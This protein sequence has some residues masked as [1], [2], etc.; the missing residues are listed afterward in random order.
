MRVKRPP[1]CLALLV[2]PVVAMGLLYLRPASEAAP[3]TVIA[4]KVLTVTMY[5]T[6]D[7]LAGGTGEATAWV[8]NDTLDRLIDIPGAYSPLYCNASYDHCLTITGEGAVNAAASLMA[9]A[10]SDRLDLSRTYLMLAG[11][12]GTPP[13]AGTLGAAAWGDWVVAAD[14]INEIDARELPLDVP[15]PKFRWGCAVPWCDTS[16]RVGVEVFR[17]N[18][19][20]T[21]WA[22][23]LS[24]DVP[25]ADNDTARAYRS[26]FP[27]GLPARQAPF[28]TTCG[29][30]SDSTFWAGTLLSNWATWWMQQWTDGQGHYCM[31]AIEDTSMLAVL[32]RLH[33][34]GRVDFNRATVLRTAS[35]FDQQHPG[36]TAQEALA[37]S[38]SAVSGG[39]DIALQNA[40]LVGSAVVREIVG[41]WPRWEAGPP[42]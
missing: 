40:Y 32:T 37:V 31:V 3:Q 26:L 28:V 1:V 24:K 17:T 13:D 18:P 8:Q 19:V 2:L 12:A 42:P 25:L 23:R 5:Q 7:P 9:I 38:M 15:Y 35:D 20:M 10:L 29:I 14:I 36:Q 16:S 41:N 22:Y 4:P 34:S 11:I 21:E 33:E 6:G 39:G 27:E 30:I